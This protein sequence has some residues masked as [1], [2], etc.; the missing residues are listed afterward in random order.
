MSASNTAAPAVRHITVDVTVN[1]VPVTLAHDRVNGLQIKEAAIA[2]GVPIDTTFKLSLEIKK[3]VWQIIGNHE[4]TDV[5]EH[6]VFRAV[7]GDDNS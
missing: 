4:E 1:H 7:S 6:A 2:A 5:T 3:G